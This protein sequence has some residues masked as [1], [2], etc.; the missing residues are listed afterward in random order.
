MASNATLPSDT[1]LDVEVNEHGDVSQLTDEEVLE[2]PWKYVGYRGYANF[3]SS[4]DDLLILRRFNSLNV[5]VILAQQD[6]LSELEQ[7]LAEIDKQ[8]SHR[9]APD[10]NNG[11]IRDDLEER[12]FLLDNIKEEIYRYSPSAQLLPETCCE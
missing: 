9:D 10:V 1:G 12:Q 4:D 7:E 8:N 3:I 11:T 2:K 5:R 6:K